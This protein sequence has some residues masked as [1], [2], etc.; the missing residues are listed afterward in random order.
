MCS[1]RA[2]VVVAAGPPRNAAGACRG[3][4]TAPPNL[5]RSCRFRCPYAANAPYVIRE[6]SAHRTAYEGVNYAAFHYRSRHRHALIAARS[7]G[8]H[9]RRRP[10]PLAAQARGR[11]ARPS[12][13]QTAAGATCSKCA[14]WSSRTAT[15]PQCHCGAGTAV[16]NK[17][18][19]FFT[20][21]IS[22]TLICPLL[23]TG[24]LE[25]RRGRGLAHGSKR[26]SRA[27]GVSLARRG[28]YPTRR[29]S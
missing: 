12:G 16:F 8:C 14:A 25:A 26:R 9:H 19:K 18:C 13:M 1:D 6:C 7:A 24:L 15:S 2:S 22:T 5:H 28:W 3:C 11:V 4:A 21:D 23:S 17:L 29:F 10:Q 27:S 20:S